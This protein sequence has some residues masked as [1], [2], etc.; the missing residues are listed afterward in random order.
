MTYQNTIEAIGHEIDLIV[1]FKIV[2]QVSYQINTIAIAAVLFG[3][4]IFLNILRKYKN[5][6][7]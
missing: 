3:H 6:F 7:S 1:E 5:K 2:R 4:I